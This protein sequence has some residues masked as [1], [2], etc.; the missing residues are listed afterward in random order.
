[1]GICSNNQKSNHANQNANN[2]NINNKNNKADNQKS[3]KNNSMSKQ[4]QA[5]ISPQVEDKDEEF[6]DLEEWEGNINN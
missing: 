4:G 1:M 2:T 6:K 3:T 5:N